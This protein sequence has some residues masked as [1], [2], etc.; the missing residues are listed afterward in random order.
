MI[1]RNGLARPWHWWG[2]RAGRVELPSE[3]SGGM[4]QRV[5]PCPCARRGDGHPA[6]GRSLL[7]AGPPHSAG[8]AGP[9]ARTAEPLG[10][11]IIF[12]THDLNE[13]MRLGDRIAVMRDGRIVQIDTAEVILQEP[14]TTTSPSSSRMST[15]PGC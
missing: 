6:D 13:A 14:R 11:T 3:L 9:A 5:G 8:D 15:A 1:G 10:K 2:W 7:R 4:K 12:I